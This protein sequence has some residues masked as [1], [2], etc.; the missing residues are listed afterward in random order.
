MEAGAPRQ[1]HQAGHYYPLTIRKLAH[2]DNWPDAWPMCRSLLCASAKVR[3]HELDIKAV[4]I[5]VYPENEDKR[6]KDEER[7]GACLDL[8]PYVH[9]RKHRGD[10]DRHS[11][12]ARA[13]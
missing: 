13:S 5:H 2:V 7:G 10:K 11:P 4:I 1:A 9:A 12:S 6:C 3:S 8:E